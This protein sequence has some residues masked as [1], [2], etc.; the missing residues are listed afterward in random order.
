MAAYFT[1]SVSFAANSLCTEHPTLL[2]EERM[3]RKLG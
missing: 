1:I 3:E 2:P